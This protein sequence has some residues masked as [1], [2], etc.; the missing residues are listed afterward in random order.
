MQRNEQPRTIGF[1][2]IIAIIFIFCARCCI[3]LFKHFQKINQPIVIHKQFFIQFTEPKSNLSVSS[4]IV[5][6]PPTLSVMDS[7][8][9][10]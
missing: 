1:F 8:T 9:K 3:S 7:V 4:F 5:L 6:F 10:P 2:I